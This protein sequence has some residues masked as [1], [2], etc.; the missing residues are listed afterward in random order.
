[1]T[2]L[3]TAPMLIAPVIGPPLGGFIA[4]WF[5][6][7]WIFY[8]NIPFGLA[9]AVLAKIFIAELGRQRRPFESHGLILAPRWLLTSAGITRLAD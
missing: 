1:M 9:G 6:C 3:F 7:P 2:N 5:T 4:T 8:L